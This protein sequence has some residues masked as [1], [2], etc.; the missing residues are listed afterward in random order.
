MIPH[1]PHARE[2]CL[3]VIRSCVVWSSRAGRRWWRRPTSHPRPR[4]LRCTP[5][6][7]GVFL[8]SIPGL[9]RSS[10]LPWNGNAC[11][12][13]ASWSRR[14]MGSFWT[15]CQRCDP[16]LDRP[17]PS[18]HDP[19]AR[20]SVA[21]RRRLGDFVEKPACG[22]PPRPPSLRGVVGV[23]PKRTPRVGRHPAHPLA[24]LRPMGPPMLRSAPRNRS[25]ISGVQSR[26]CFALHGTK[27]SVGGADGGVEAH[28]GGIRRRRSSSRATLNAAC[29]HSARHIQE[30]LWLV[31]SPLDTWARG[32]DS[33][34]AR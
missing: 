5:M 24:D 8:N 9:R 31:T 17:A 7:Y 21:K 19:R 12:M 4:W 32:P 27:Q 15:G 30:R 23:A 28:A 2:G 22:A 6:G 34:G 10:S 3:R 18:R 29:S 16:L 25:A 11:W 33:C 20:S 1:N 26:K 13:V 14:G